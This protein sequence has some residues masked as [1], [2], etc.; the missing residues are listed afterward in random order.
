[1]RSFKDVKII[2]LRLARPLMRDG[3]RSKLI[4]TL[5]ALTKHME[6]VNEQDVDWRA[7][8]LMYLY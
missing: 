6:E 5:K 8:Y 3:I 4:P 7:R 2:Y 1:M